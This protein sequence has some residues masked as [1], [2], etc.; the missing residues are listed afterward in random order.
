[1]T[2]SGAHT[3]GHVHVQNTPFIG[4][5]PSSSPNIVDNA[6]DDTPAAF[7][8][9]YYMNLLNTVSDLLFIRNNNNNNTSI[10][11]VSLI[12]IYF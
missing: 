3:I 8:N 5:P 12:I 11:Q 6:W 7:D 1:V 2:L 10:T 9:R 4:L